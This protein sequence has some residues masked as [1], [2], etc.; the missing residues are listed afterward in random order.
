MEGFLKTPEVYSLVPL[1]QR[2]YFAT[3]YLATE[4]FYHT[5]HF[6]SG[7]FNILAE[8]FCKW[9]ANF[10]FP[11][12]LP[13]VNLFRRDWQLQNIFQTPLLLTKVQKESK[14]KKSLWCRKCRTSENLSHFASDRL[15]SIITFPAVT[16]LSDTKGALYTI[17]DF[18]RLHVLH[19]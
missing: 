12:F 5:L 13:I 17:K 19:F 10:Q 18:Y 14:H 16:L 1:T 6:V 4:Y 15:C 8:I 3:E 9:A 7:N 11:S 2:E